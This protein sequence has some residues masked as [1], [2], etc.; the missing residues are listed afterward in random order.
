M[1]IGVINMPGRNSFAGQS[2]KPRFFILGLPL[3]P[4][5]CIYKISDNIG[6]DVPLTGTDILHAFAKIHFGLLGIGGLFWMSNLY[7]EDTITKGILLILSLALLGFC[8]YSW[9]AHSEAPKEEATRRR[10]F[11]K[12]F[13]YNMSPEYL[14]VAVQKSLFA[15]LIKIYFGKF[16][17]LNW[18]KN[19]Q[20]GHVTKSNFALLYT[21]AYYQK[22]L[23]N[24]SENQALFSEIE[25]YLDKNK[26][27]KPQEANT[28]AT[29][30][31]PHSATQASTNDDSLNAKL[32][33]F[34][35]IVE[36]AANTGP[37][38]EAAQPKASAANTGQNSYSSQ[39][40][41]YQ[42]TTETKE[43]TSGIEQMV[44]G[45][46]FK[47]E[48]ALSS[49]TKQL[50]IVFG[51]FAFGFI[52]VSFL[53]A[54]KSSLIPVFFICLAL[55]AIISAFVFLPSFLKIKKDMKNRKKVRLDV[56][57]RD[58]TE[59]FGT[60]YFVLKPNKHRITKLTA[61][62]KFY[63]TSLLNKTL[64]IYVAKESH[65]LLEIINVRY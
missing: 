42:Q 34:K 12:A 48:D 18:Q 31:P 54:N 61:P 17:E 33:E 24:S 15:E 5:G 4:T 21:L 3:F 50:F 9:I 2:I 58:L 53:T 65:T 32:E 46:I 7:R 56:Q 40:S 30:P 41:A 37:S 10:I 62:A 6:I 60:A 36:A 55:Y 8:I 28:A 63:S 38:P 29:T 57:I 45:D 44:K 23:K 49:I 64:D 47:L 11:G 22:T 20:S 14:P 59:E 35:R 19:I 27:I 52:I 1:R 13:L 26:K 25:S 43:S 51:F 16:S 39:S